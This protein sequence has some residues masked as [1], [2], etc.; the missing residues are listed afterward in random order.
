[1]KQNMLF[2]III[3]IITFSNSCSKSETNL[4]APT[5]TVVITDTANRI[6]LTKIEIHST[7]TAIQSTSNEKIIP[8]KIDFPSWVINNENDILLT[9]DRKESSH[10]SIILYGTDRPLSKWEPNGFD[11]M[12]KGLSNQGEYF[13]IPLSNEIFGYFWLDRYT[14]GL[15]TL[16]LDEIITI[17]I[18]SGETKNYPIDPQIT[19][20]IQKNNNDTDFQKPYSLMP[21]AYNINDN[22]FFLILSTDRYQYSYDWKYRILIT[23]DKEHKSLKYE[24]LSIHPGIDI[25]LKTKIDILYYSWPTN[26][27][28]KLLISEGHDPQ[29]GAWVDEQTEK[30]ETA[31]YKIIPEKNRIE[32]SIK[33]PLNS[34]WSLDDNI[35]LYDG[36]EG[37]P[38]MFTIDRE[39]ISCFQDLLK[40]FKSNIIAGAIRKV[41]ISGF[42][43]INSDSI[44]LIGYADIAQVATIPQL[45]KLGI[46]CIL[47]ISKNT[48]FCPYSGFDSQGFLPLTYRVSSS[49]KNAILELGKSHYTTSWIASRNIMLGLDEE[50]SNFRILDESGIW[51]NY[52]DYLW[53]PS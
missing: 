46:F 7:Q 33:A 47:S 24:I 26:S 21:S 37:V 35:L 8:L 20:Y 30:G 40:P 41:Y 12:P 29:D 6:S 43:Q 10:N 52:F 28:D 34:D 5:H 45:T 13:E 49:K 4:I 2:T 27:S 32:L 11:S 14:I 23:D 51:V 42:K 15:L 16:N 38:C 39:T 22:N 19:R 31:I 3:I 36:P 18:N 9:F 25:E 53:R 17:N 1:M 50:K 48:F 44:A